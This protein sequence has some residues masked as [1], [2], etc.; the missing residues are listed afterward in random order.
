M[1]S[2]KEVFENKIEIKKSSFIAYLCPFCEFYALKETLKLNNPKANHI[3]WAYRIINEYD[4]IVENSSD[5]KE[6]KGTSGPPIL[7]VLRG[8]ELVECACLIVRYFGGVKL[9]T[10]GLVRAYSSSCNEVIKVANL[11]EYE[12]LISVKFF[13]QFNILSRFEH[14]FEVN[15]YPK[16]VKD[17]VQN[18]VKYQMDLT[19]TQILNLENFS[20]EF[21][22]VGFEFK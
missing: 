18:G 17:F 20:L 22:H 21:L 19:K 1:K 16:G 5:D 7:N 6:P 14:F 3:V 15:L 11:V 13:I 4:Q 10:G 2:I 8:F 9:G 12:K